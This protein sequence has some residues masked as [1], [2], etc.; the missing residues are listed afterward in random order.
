MKVV[1]VLGSPTRDGNTCVLAREVLRGAAESGA[2]TEEILLADHR[3]EFCRGCIS[4]NPKACCMA[5]GVCVINDD[6]KVLKQKLAEANGIVLASPSYGIMESA[7]MKNFLVDRIGMYTAYTSGLAGKYFVGISTCGGIG[8][9]TVA[10]NLSKHFLAG[11]HRRGY[12]TGYIGVKLGYDRIEQHPRALA[13]AHALGRKL[14]DD[15][16]TRRT[17]PLQMLFDRIMIALIVRRIILNNI[18]ANR[19]GVMK[20]VYRDLVEREIIKPAD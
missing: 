11:F 3:I 14:V 2:Q 15:I 6:V 1:A 12:R 17:Y 19:D 20:A 5:T 10:R 8:A 9:T 13:R 4:R 16:N 7:R 18:H